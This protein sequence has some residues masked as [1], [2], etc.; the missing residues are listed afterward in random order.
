MF[1]TLLLLQ[2]KGDLGLILNVEEILIMIPVGLQQSRFT[3]QHLI[4]V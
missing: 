2:K 4:N 3:K 1:V